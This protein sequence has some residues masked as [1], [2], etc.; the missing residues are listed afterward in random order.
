MADLFNI[1]LPPDLDYGIEPAVRQLERT[2]LQELDRLWP[3]QQS[4]TTGTQSPP[5]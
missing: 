3:V 2:L 5:R 4:T 1:A